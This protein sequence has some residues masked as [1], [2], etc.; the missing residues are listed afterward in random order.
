MTSVSL[1][2]ISPTVREDSCLVAEPSL[3]TSPRRLPAPGTPVGRAS[4]PFDSRLCWLASCRI[5]ALRSESCSPVPIRKVPSQHLSSFAFEFS[6]QQQAGA[7]A[8]RSTRGCNQRDL[9]HSDAL[10]L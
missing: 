1:R 2:G 5:H 6:G 8:N 10:R 3:S 7:K 9:R 4:A